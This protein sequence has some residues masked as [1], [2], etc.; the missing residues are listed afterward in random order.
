MNPVDKALT[1]VFKP[2]RLGSDGSGTIV[3]VG[4][5]VNQD[6]VGKKVAFTYEAWGEYKL[7]YP[8]KV[9]VLD[10]S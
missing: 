3:A 10:D 7:D 9:V 8:N 5:G 4:N 2:E 1:F 6:L